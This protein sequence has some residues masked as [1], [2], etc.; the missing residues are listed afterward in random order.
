MRQWVILI[1]LLVALYSN[2]QERELTL[3]SKNEVSVSPWEEVSLS[4]A[5]KIHYTPERNSVDLKYSE[6]FIAHELKH[7]VEYS[8]GFRH[9]KLNIKNG[10]WLDENRPM[11]NINLIKNIEKFQF[12]FSNRLEYRL[13]KESNDY[14]RHRQSLKFNFPNITEWGMQF[15]VSEESF[16]KLNGAGTHLARVYTGLKAVDKAHF[17]INLYYSLQKAK[18]LNEWLTS[19]VVGLNLSF[20]I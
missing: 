18:F 9:S 1:L 19:D 20:D 6:V 8:F 14:F 4:V 3:W 12:S 17:D 16:L 10:N 11:F 5:Q 13:F 2:A 7:W 15:Y